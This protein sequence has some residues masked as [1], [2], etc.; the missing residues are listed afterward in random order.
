MAM[1]LEDKAIESRLTSL[2]KGRRLPEWKPPLRT[3]QSMA[4]LRDITGA[5]VKKTEET[6]YLLGKEFIWLKNKLAG[7]K[8]AYTNAVLASGHTLRT[9][10]RLAEHARECDDVNRLLP[11]Q[12]N[13]KH[14]GDTVTL[15]EPPPI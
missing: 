14:K 4:R 12:P 13:K 15:L 8:G 10:Q 7:I 9:A 2:P 11:Y 5:W 3:K 6:A 1:N